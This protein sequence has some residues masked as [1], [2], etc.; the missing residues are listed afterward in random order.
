MMRRSS[1]FRS[2]QLWFE[3]LSP[4]KVPSLQLFC[5][6]YAGGSA[7]V[8]RSWQRWLPEQ[9][10]IC[11]VHLPGRGRSTGE[12]PFRRLAP[13][14]NAVADHMSHQIN[15]PYA[16]YG[17]SM[18]ALICFELARELSRRR[19]SGPQHL[20]VSGRRAP[21]WPMDP[22]TYNLPYE[23]FL[24]ELRRLNG[25]PQEV[26]DNPEL[27]ELYIDILRADFEVVDTYEYY[28]SGPLPCGITVYGGLE[29]ERVPAESCHA[30]RE[31]T[32]AGCKVAMFRGDHFFIRK[33]SPEFIAAFRGDLLN[34]LS[35]PRMTVI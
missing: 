12:P 9:Y 15:F 17:H 18:G 33:P 7:E 34:V 6:P 16:L 19:A 4:A 26:V 29:D 24:G 25:T 13:L 14:V 21:Q 22:S 11:L 20:F 32:S 2:G 31:Q 28:P 35:L 5:F 30:W 23:E 10:D 1:A 3:H 8:Y 27:M